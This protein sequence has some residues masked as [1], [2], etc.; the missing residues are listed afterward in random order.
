MKEHMD[1]KITLLVAVLFF[2]LMTIMDWI[3]SFFKIHITISGHSI[4]M[5]PLE[6][7]IAALIITA[8]LSI[9]MFRS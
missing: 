5:M 7:T 8:T 9:W 4:P 6:A 1:K 2:G 3:C